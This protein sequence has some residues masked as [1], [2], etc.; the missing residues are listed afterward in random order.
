VPADQEQVL[1]LGEA[2]LHERESQEEKLS[3]SWYYNFRHRHEHKIQFVYYQNKDKRRS[4]AE[5][6][7]IIVD[8]FEKVISGSSICF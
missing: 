2:L 6:W 8:F 5:N 4:N 3:T 7:D 1:E